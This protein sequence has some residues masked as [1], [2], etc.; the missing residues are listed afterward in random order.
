MMP[1]RVTEADPAHAHA[2]FRESWF[3]KGIS[4]ISTTD[5]VEAV[6]ETSISPLY[7]AHKSRVYLAGQE[8]LVCRIIILISHIIT[9]VIPTINLLTKSP[10]L[11]SRV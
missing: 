10:G 4:G 5:L 1:G 3:I 11:P 2:L 9:P 7:S 6:R 8:D